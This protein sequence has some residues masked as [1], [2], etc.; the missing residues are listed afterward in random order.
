M[1]WRPTPDRPASRAVRV[2][3]FGLV[4]AALS[5]VAAKLLL[6]LAAHAFVRVIE[7]LMN[8]CVW[9]AMSLSAGVSAGSMLATIGRNATGLMNTRQASLVLTLL[10]AVAALAAYGLQRLLGSDEESSR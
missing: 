3:G 6:P 9:L 10:M 1:D 7:M 2:A 4:A 5:V 8:A